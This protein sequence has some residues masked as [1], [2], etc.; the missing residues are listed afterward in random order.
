[1]NNSFF[2]IAVVTLSVLASPVAAA[3]GGGVPKVPA[4]SL[5]G[6]TG[7]SLSISMRHM[8]RTIPDDFAG[9]AAQVARLQS[10]LTVSRMT[11]ATG[12]ISNSDIAAAGV[13]E[14]ALREPAKL[15]ERR[16]TLV[17]AMGEAH[18]EVLEG[19]AKLPAVRQLL[20]GAQSGETGLAKMGEVMDG[21]AARDG[22][23]DTPAPAAPALDGS[24]A[25]E[26]GLRDAAARWPGA[27]LAGAETQSGP[28]A[29]APTL[30]GYS[31]QLWFR[32]P[33]QGRLQSLRVSRYG[34]GPGQSVPG[35]SGAAAES[36]SEGV[37]T[38]ADLSGPELDRVVSAAKAGFGGSF[39]PGSLLI[40]ASASGPIYRFR[41][42]MALEVRVQGGRIVGEEDLKSPSVPAVAAP[43]APVKQRAV[44]VGVVAGD[45]ASVPSDA[46]ITAINS[47][48]MW[49]G[50]IDRV[51]MRFSGAG[52]QYHEQAAAKMPLK[53][54]DT[55]VADKKAPHN[56]K[57]DKVVFV[58]DDLKRPL[59]E[60]VQRGLIAADD[61]GL[62]TV[63]V[64]AIRMGVMLG[65]VE[66]SPK[67][68]VMEIALGIKTFVENHIKNIERITF[69]IFQEPQTPPILLDAIKKLQDPRIT[70]KLLGTGQ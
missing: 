9:E 24:F 4:L 35:P 32:V 30:R 49:A 16:D 53:D 65:V 61:A 23:A 60:I 58:V 22:L 7:P 70:V 5:P 41:D 2:L 19:L 34:P 46:I 18:Y 40:E 15:A 59:R 66:K 50:G 17:A 52:G 26:L 64:P 33:G 36:Y 27:E 20:D 45:I 57:Y 43:V 68:A 39:R 55:V 10:V 48:G 63:T 69:V 6:V 31:W 44:E 47:G 38:Q 62:K 14:Q 42:H 1:M 54:G 11:A 25:V 67:D 37:L 51:I 12:L 13:I 56:G 28:K 29:Q 21:S 3:P 8:M